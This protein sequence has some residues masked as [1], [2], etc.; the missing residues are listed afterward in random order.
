MDLLKRLTLPVIFTLLA[1]A[2]WNSNAFREIAAGVAIFL[3]GMLSLEQGFRVFSGGVLEKTLRYCTNRVWKSL[4]FGVLTTSLMQS[5]SLVSV[6]AISFLSAGL[7]NLSMGLGIIFGANLGTTT[8]AWLVAALG[9]K[10]KLSSYA[11]PLLVFGVA[12]M[13]QQKNT[14]QGLGRILVGIGFL[15]LGIDQMKTGFAE[16]QQA[17]D[18]SLYHS[19]GWDGRLLYLGIGLLATVIMQSSHATL[20][21]IL[22]A[23]SSGHIS[24]S[25]ALALAIGAN[26]GTTITALLGSLSANHAGRQLALGHLMFNLLTA[27]TALLLLP[28]LLQLVEWCAARLGLAADDFTLR[29]AIFHTLFNTLG[30][31][32]MLPWLN[33]LVMLL[34]SWL[35]E[36]RSHIKRPEYL[37]DAALSSVSG[38][39]HA[40]RQESKRLYRFGRDIIIRGLGWASA[41]FRQQQLPDDNDP[42]EVSYHNIQ[43]SYDQRLKH[44]HADIT[45]FI[46]LAREHAPQARSEQLR[47]LSVACF[48]LIEAVKDTK[49]MQRN[50][51]HYANGNNQ[52]MTRAYQQLRQDIAHT[53]LKIDQAGKQFEQDQDQGELQLEL[54]HLQLLANRHHQEF[55]QQIELLIRS[56]EISAVMAT[57]LMNDKEYAYRISK[58]LLKAARS[59]WLLGQ[60]TEKLGL[61]DNELSDIN[62]QLS[63]NNSQDPESRL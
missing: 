12:L 25:D 21:L 46:S 17:V 14:S 41:D 22:T 54:E 50:L 27:C 61:E 24:Y 31:L 9:L 35:P 33:R 45:R 26:I 2:L 7:I 20:V 51:L 42:H 60:T 55:D 62:Q 40:A 34:Q 63:D 44:L 58:N 53:L 56:D 23:L 52:A 1:L 28:Q 15:F 10:I 57:S 32:L 5:S 29:L 19:N 30:V 36:P 38:S 39:L 18:L 6:L 48:H 49:H 43:D 37:N 13:F 3:F 59:L 11:M 47:Q 4:T 16:F 8:G